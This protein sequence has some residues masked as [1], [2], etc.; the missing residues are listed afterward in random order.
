MSDAP[1]SPSAFASVA[2]GLFAT[3][4][5][6]AFVF[7]VVPGVAH[8]VAPLLCSQ[9]FV[10]VPSA[11]RQ[12]H[13][14]LCRGPDGDTDITFVASLLTWVVLWVALSATIYGVLW[15]RSRRGKQADG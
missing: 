6:S 1:R 5:T 4:P 9:A 13:H 11:R 14:Y 15:A 3:M 7:N 12:S 2:I 8:A 10:I